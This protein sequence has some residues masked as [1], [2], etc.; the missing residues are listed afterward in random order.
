MSDYPGEGPGSR[1]R[2]ERP[3]EPQDE[4]RPTAPLSG[5]GQPE[6]SRSWDPTPPPTSP[7]Q[8]SPYQQG[9]YQQGPYPQPTPYAGAAPLGY[10]PPPGFAHTAPDHPQALTSMLVGILGLVLG[11]STCGLGLV[12]SPF[13]WV[14]GSKA[15][16]QIRE[17]QGRY[18]GES[19]ARAGHVTGIVGTVLLVIALIAVVG[20]IALAVGTASYSDQGVSNV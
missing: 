16:R 8:Q 1:P 18:G 10:P 5:W 9:S 20:F 6:P 12:A 3:E 13:A 17:S 11:L 2:E 14:M 7:Q 4:P 15:L 19:M